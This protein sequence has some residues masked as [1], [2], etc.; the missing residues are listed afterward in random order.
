MYYQTTSNLQSLWPLIH[1][2]QKNFYVI[3][4]FVQSANEFI[5]MLVFNKHTRQPVQDK[6]IQR[7]QTAKKTQWIWI[8]QANCW[9]HQTFYFVDE[10][11]NLVSMDDRIII[12]IHSKHLY[13]AP[14]KNGALNNLKKRNKR[15]VNQGNKWVFSCR[16]ILA[17][18]ALYEI[19]YKQTNL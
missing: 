17:V 15:T 6:R 9:F 16:L 14:I 3:R 11:T 12:L 4:W 13:S 19:H 5:H 10:Q 8:L 18:Q 2:C 7:G 1:S